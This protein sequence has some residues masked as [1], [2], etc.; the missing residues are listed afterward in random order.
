MDETNIAVTSFRGYRDASSGERASFGVLVSFACTIAIARVINYVRERQRAFPRTR[1]RWRRVYNW[2][3]AGGTRVH[4][5]VPGI[6][7]AFGAGGTAII[8]RT[9]GRE[10]LFSIP[11]GIGAGLTADEIALLIDVD[12]PY[13]TSERFAIYQAAAAGLGAAALGAR[14]AS[15]SRQSDTD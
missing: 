11:F 3:R 13:W 1:G 8:T 4:H 12:N 14:F 6:A 5:F 9:D 15:H 10:L 2:P 7:L